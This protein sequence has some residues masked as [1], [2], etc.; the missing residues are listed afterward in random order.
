MQMKRAILAGAL[1]FGLQGQPA[2]AQGGPPE[3]PPGKPLFTFHS[4]FWVNLHHFLYVLGRAR[5]DS[6]DS[7]RR[8]V[9]KA[10]ADLDGFNSLKAQE[11]QT[12]DDAIGHYRDGPSRRDVIF[13]RELSAV[14]RALAVVDDSAPLT[15]VDLP[16]PFRETLERAAPIYRKV[17]W[18][19][20]SGSNQARIE[21][22]QDLLLRYGRHV[23][24]MLTGAYQKKWPDT[25]FIV[26]ISAY[27]NW[28]GAYSVASG[29]IVMASTDEGTAGSEALEAIF[30]EAMHQWDDAIIP[31]LKGTTE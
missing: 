11:R 21:E 17:W 27:C 29:P 26:Q 14:T 4:G 15:G 20:H 2:F 9:S 16:A 12:W 8:A 28:A 22:L 25:G 10:P 23:S 18:H 30:H 6:P 7:Q 24:E 1:L 3:T 31:L 19:R 13:D 5:N